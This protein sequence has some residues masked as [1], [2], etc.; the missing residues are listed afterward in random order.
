MAVCVLVSSTKIKRSLSSKLTWARNAT[1]LPSSR[2][3]ATSVFFPRQVQALEYTPD[4][5]PTC[6]PPQGRHHVG[7][8]LVDRG[9]MA[10]LQDVSPHL[11]PLPRPQPG[12]LAP[13]VRLGRQAARLAPLAQE[14]LDERAAHAKERGHF[15]L[16]PY[17]AIH[18]LYHTRPQV[19]RISA[20]A[21]YLA[22]LPRLMQVRH[23]LGSRGFCVSCWEGAPRARKFPLSR[24]SRPKH[25]P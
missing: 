6:L 11:L 16:R 14:L 13:A 17:P 3:L 21:S 22:K 15:L 8:D 12:D 1:R 10:R 4:R 9:V 5:G 2:S 19:Q 24:S 23:A 7:M 25:L 20:H 18:R